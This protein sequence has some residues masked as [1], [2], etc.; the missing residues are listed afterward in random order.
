MTDT[1]LTA[2]TK[3][4]ERD[5]ARFAYRRW[6]KKGGTPL[7]FLQHF[8]GGMDHWDPLM[9]DGLAEGREVILYDGR[10]VS[11]ST[12]VTPDRFEAMA[13][14]LSE[15]IL[16]IG[17][18]QVDVV[19]FS[20]GGMQAQELTLRHP[21]LVRKLM[22]LGTGPRGGDPWV[23]PRMG[24][25][26]AKPVHGAD[27]F[28]FLFF[29][30]SDQAKKAGHEFWARR[31]Q[32]TVDEDPLSDEATAGAQWAAYLEYMKPVGEKP[33]AHLNAI[34]QPT[35]VVNGNRDIMIATINSFHLQQNIPNSE[36][37]IYPD[38]G[39]GSHFQYPDR[40]LAHARL[41]LDR[42]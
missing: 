5:G 26:A 8:R 16:G 14:D 35:L 18:K 34:R 37:I 22:L 38:S 29:G 33:Y 12:G 36:L 15:F 40:F 23:D 27:D 19:G 24:A 1:H 10:G 30:E 39:H 3:F 20:I 28:V 6:G 4:L 32:R 41:F 31:H 21:E 11:S 42:E 13:D 17:L 7:I 25:V 9:T 2:Q